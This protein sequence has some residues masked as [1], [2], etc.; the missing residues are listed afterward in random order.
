MNLLKRKKFRRACHGV[1]EGIR[2]ENSFKV[3]LTAAALAIIVSIIIGISPDEWCLILLVIGLV[4]VSEMFNTVIELLVRL[5][6]AQYHE[7]AEKL[8]NIS[9]GAVM[10]SS[11][12]ALIVGITIFGSRLVE[13]YM[14][15]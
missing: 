12:V 3:H 10:I 8:L 9:A 4:L 7:L 5:Y 6:T 1:L 13:I 11:I 2:I 15:L 14:E